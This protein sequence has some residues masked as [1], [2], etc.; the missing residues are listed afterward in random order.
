MLLLESYMK[1]YPVITYL[2]IYY[3]YIILLITSTRKTL[4]YKNLTLHKGM[5]RSYYKI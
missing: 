2:T 1:R 5:Y 3:D 4:K